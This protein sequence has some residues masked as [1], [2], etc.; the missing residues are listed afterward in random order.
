M[1]NPKIPIVIFPCFGIAEP[2]SCLNVVPGTSE[3]NLILLPFIWN[4]LRMGNKII[5]DIGIKRMP[6]L[7]KFEEFSC[8]HG[9]SGFYRLVEFHLREVK[10][11]YPGSFMTY[12]NCSF[13]WI[14][15]WYSAVDKMRIL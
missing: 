10:L 8:F 12:E 2:D 3:M 15:W 6:S 11:P 7:Q 5:T 13:A 9:L 1:R 4:E 14:G